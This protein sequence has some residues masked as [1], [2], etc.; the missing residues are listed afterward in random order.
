MRPETCM[1]WLNVTVCVKLPGF[2][3]DG[4]Y[5]SVKLSADMN[6]NSLW[7]R[8][9]LQE[10]YLYKACCILHVMTHFNTLKSG[11][12]LPLQQYSISHCFSYLRPLCG[13]RKHSLCQKLCGSGPLCTKC[14]VCSGYVLL[15]WSIEWSFIWDAQVT[16]C[17]VDCSLQERNIPLPTDLCSPP[18]MTGCCKSGN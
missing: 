18:A 4:V 6:A 9:F 2:L 17:L 13:N 7:V 16:K 15:V 8:R 1:P 12:V 3:A 11:A 14:H 5:T 10:A